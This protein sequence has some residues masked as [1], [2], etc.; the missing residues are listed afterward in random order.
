MVDDEPFNPAPRE[1]WLHCPT[2]Q[3]AF[4]RRL[5]AVLAAPAPLAP[6]GG[7]GILYVGGGKF[8]PGIVVGVRLLRELGCTLPVQVWHR[9]TCEPVNPA[10]VAGLGVEIIDADALSERLDDNRVPRGDVATGGWEAKTYALTHCPFRRALYLD[11]DA[12]CVA[13]PAPLFAA[14]AGVGF[15]FWSDLPHCEH[16]VRWPAVW[17]DGAAGVPTFQ[18][19]QYVLDRAVGGRAL[20]AAHFMNQHS[21]FYFKHLF[22]DQDCFRVALAATGVPYR[23]LGPADWPG[24]AFVC[25]VDASPVVV[26]RCQGKLFRPHEIPAGAS[27]HSNPQGHLPRE[28]R[29]FDLLAEQFNRERQD[30]AVFDEH[31]RRR[32]WGED[33]SGAGS[34]PA[35][36][37][38]F[39][40]TVRAVAPLAGW[41]SCVDVGCGD[42][43]VARALPFDHYRGFDASAEAVTRFRQTAPDL[44]AEVLDCHRDLERLP[45]AD[46]LLCRDVLHHWPNAWVTDWLAR[47]RAA[48]KWRAV[49]LSQDRHQWHDGQDTWVGGYRALK[50]DWMPLRPFNCRVLAEY[51][52]KAILVLPPETSP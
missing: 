1:R 15:A 11:A 31:Y 7:D 49:L 40:E 41:R 24:T 39:V 37:A 4:R 2:T 6:E 10:D 23:C 17:P 46:V 30:A 14:C 25:R 44:S 34:T 36:A 21:D 45:P 52:H 18:G 29:V 43:R 47:V 9:G 16:N 20:A 42:G 3:A 13:D 12:Y 26:H 35:E 48:G 8:W 32:L 28:G 33:G 38:P 27:H 51:L 19:G 22:G 50:P 5:A